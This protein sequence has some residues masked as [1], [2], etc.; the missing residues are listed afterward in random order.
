[1]SNIRNGRTG[2]P[3]VLAQCTAG[4][5]SKK[6]LKLFLSVEGS[7]HLPR[8]IILNH[9]DGTQ[10]YLPESLLQPLQSFNATVQGDFFFAHVV[11]PPN[12]GPPPTVHPST[13]ASLNQENRFQPGHDGLGKYHYQFS[14]LPPL[15][16]RLNDSYSHL[17]IYPFI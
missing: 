17:F 4:T 13:L 9:N 8:N 6:L 1:M 14:I 10:T 7:A 11:L 15:V 2:P 12:V 3:P 5:N 16:V